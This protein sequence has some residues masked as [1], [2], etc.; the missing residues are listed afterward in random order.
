MID[1]YII[2]AFIILERIHPMVRLPFFKEG[3]LTDFFGYIIFQQLILDLCIFDLIKKLSYKHAFHV[4]SDLSLVIQFVIAFFLLEFCYYWY[5]RIAHESDFIWRFHELHH[6]STALNWASG[7]RAHVLD[8]IFL[9]LIDIS[10]FSLLGVNTTVIL[11]LASVSFGH[12]MYKHS[13]FRN[14][15]GFLQYFI[16]STEM[17]HCHHLKDVKY[18]KSNYG[19]TLSLYD[20]IFGTAYYP[21]EEEYR[22]IDYGTNGEYPQKYIA[23]NIH[24]FRRIK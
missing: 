10:I 15:I 12:G 18:Q 8:V 5:H 1:I 16:Q 11:A 4:I 22:S 6:S 7:A 17:H 2:A 21:K 20:W 24:V 14:K 19:N 3:F 23:Q 9:T 13:N